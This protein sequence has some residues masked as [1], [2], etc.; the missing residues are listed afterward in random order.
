[1]LGSLARLF[2]LGRSAR[3]PEFTVSSGKGDGD[4]ADRPM[5]RLRGVGRAFGSGAA[6]SVALDGVDLEI[7]R[8]EFVGVDGPSGS[9]KTTLLSILGLLDTPTAGSYLLNGRAVEDMPAAQRARTRNREIGFIFQSFNLIGDMSVFEN[10]DLPL[11]YLGLPGGE[12]RDRVREALHRV[13][14]ASKAGSYPSQLSGGHQQRVAVARAVVGEPQILL[15]DEPT[16][17]LNSEEASV[18]IEMLAELHDAG[19]TICLVTHDSRWREV[20]RRTVH[21]FDGRLV[22]PAQGRPTPT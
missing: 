16:G 7:E 9:G 13:G 14:M 19:S 4:A 6:R 8:G 18:V 11:S 3:E 12:R 21:L 1:M 22:E 10:V 5:I 20:T 2:G 15:A 17:N